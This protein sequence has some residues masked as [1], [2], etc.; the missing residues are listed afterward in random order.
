MRED[1]IYSYIHTHTFANIHKH[2]HIHTCIHKHTR[3]HT[4][5]QLGFLAAEYAGRFNIF[6]Q[7]ENEG[8]NEDKKK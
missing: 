6:V 7:D 2:T 5:I 8:E 3:I 1:S 4:Y